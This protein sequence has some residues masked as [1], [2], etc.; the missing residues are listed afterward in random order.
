VAIWVSKKFGARMGISPA[1]QRLMR[2]LAGYNLGVATGFLGT[3]SEF[4]NESRD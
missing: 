4:E 1:M 2:A 3:L